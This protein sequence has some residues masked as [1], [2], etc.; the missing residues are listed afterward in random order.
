MGARD[1]ASCRVVTPGR[2]IAGRRGRAAAAAG[3][4]T[5]ALTVRGVVTA[6]TVAAVAVWSARRGAMAPVR[7]AAV[8]PVRVTAV[9]PVRVAAVVPV[10]VTAVMPGRVAAVGVA[11]VRVAAVAPV[12]VAAVCITVAEGRV[13]A[14]GAAVGPLAG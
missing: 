5:V 3:V 10:R 11:A 6:L 1:I 2:C 4:V 9:V 13:L 8:M 12:R 14:D 7:V